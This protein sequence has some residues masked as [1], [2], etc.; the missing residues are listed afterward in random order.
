MY[1]ILYDHGK[2]VI[3]FYMRGKQKLFGRKLP[4]DSLFSNKGEQGSVV[5][6][7]IYRKSERK[8]LKVKSKGYHSFEKCRCGSA[9][10]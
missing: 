3:G 10:K 6:L 1:K 7:T 5:E 4:S 9:L 2:A 8:R